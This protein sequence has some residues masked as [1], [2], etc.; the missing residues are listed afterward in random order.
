MDA[1]QLKV[2]REL[3]DHLQRLG[4]AND[5]AD[6]GCGEEA[7]RMRTEACAS[8]SQLLEQHPFL[9]DLLPSLRQ[10]LDTG[11]IQWFGWSR[12][13]DEI[14]PHLEGSE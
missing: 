1:R 8:I 13:L 3:S 12:L 6:H 4:S 11:N 5:A 10:E 2:L 7:E 14:E 9:A